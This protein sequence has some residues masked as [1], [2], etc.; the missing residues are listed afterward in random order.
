[1]YLKTHSWGE[2]IFDWIWAD[3]YQRSGYSYYPKLIVQSPFTPLTSPKLLVAPDC[4]S[5]ATR[6]ALI[7]TAAEALNQFQVSS[8]HLLFTTPEEASLLKESGFHSRT[9]T[10]EFVWRNRHYT[11]MEEFLASLS[12]KKRK[13]IRQ[14]RSLVSR[15]G[16][17]VE[18]VS[19]EEIKAK[20]WQALENFYTCTVEKYGSIKYLTHE[21]FRA[22]GQ[23]MPDSIVLFLAKKNGQ[24]IGGSVCLQGLESMYGRYWGATEEFRALH[25]EVCYYSAIEYCIQQGLLQYNVGVQGEHKLGRGFLPEITHSAHKFANS[26]FGQQIQNYIEREANQVKEYQMAL[27]SKSPYKEF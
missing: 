12:S 27:S 4:D 15:Q 23:S 17:S 3:A 25:F 21:F 10:V 20:H 16:I 8:I 6:R 13:N 1:M 26:E 7:A 14:E 22:V 24:Y 19:G 18:V 11:S 2:F 5:T 9:G